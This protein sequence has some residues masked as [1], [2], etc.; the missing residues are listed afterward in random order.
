VSTTTDDVRLE[1]VE[2]LLVLNI[3]PS[4]DPDS[5]IQDTVALV[6]QTF[7]YDPAPA[8]PAGIR[9]GGAPAWRTVMDLALPSLSGP[10]ELCAAVGCP[11]T[12]E[13]GHISYAGLVLTTRASE[14][15]YEPLDTIMLDVRPVLAPAEL[16]KSPLGPSQTGGVGSAIAPEAF[17]A[18]AGSVVEVPITTF[19]RSLLG[20]PL[21]GFEPP[22][23]LA[24]LALT[25]PASLP[26]ASF[27]GP[28]A[29]GEPA[30][31]LIL[32]VGNPQV[33]P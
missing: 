21:G 31:S 28:T 15:G 18:M 29:P 13:S 2:A 7:I 24:L 5:V 6:Q 10:P 3:R 9:V 17:G 33:L 27:D 11:Y 14:S 16:P 19:M 20:P 23:T 4:L 22:T 1:L 12:L 32:T 25:E 8:A 26:F 30:L